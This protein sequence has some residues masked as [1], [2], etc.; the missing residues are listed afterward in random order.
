MCGSKQSAPAPA[1]VA[2]PDPTIAN[3]G[4]SAATGVG[5]TKRISATGEND[6]IAGGLSGSA[7]PAPVAKSVLG[8]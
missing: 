3:R 1:P 7:T 2:V 4:S 5:D 8:G 6:G